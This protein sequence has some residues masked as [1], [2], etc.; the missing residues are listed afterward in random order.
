VFAD[1]SPKKQLLPP[2]Y[3]FRSN[4]VNFVNLQAL[5]EKIAVLKPPPWPFD[6]NQELVDKGRILFATNCGSCHEEKRLP[7]GTWQITNFEAT[8]VPDGTE[9]RHHDHGQP[10]PPPAPTQ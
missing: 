10:P 1:F 5:E 6:L 4:S 9:H 7:N 2:H 8:R 3:N